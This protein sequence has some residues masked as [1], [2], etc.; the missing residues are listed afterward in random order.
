M[1]EAT[2]SRRKYLLLID[3]LHICAVNCKQ[4]FKEVEKTQMN[5]KIGDKGF[6]YLET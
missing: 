3:L 5:K 4:T 6:C 1:L 2:N